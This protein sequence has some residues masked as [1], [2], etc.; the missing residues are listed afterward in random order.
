[1]DKDSRSLFDEL[2][3]KQPHE[4]R[5]SDI[6]FLRARESY[7]TSDQ[8]EKFGEV[9]GLEKPKAEKKKADK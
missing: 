6:E 4:F 7:L 1:M 9:I 8:R 3:S 5:Q 2:M